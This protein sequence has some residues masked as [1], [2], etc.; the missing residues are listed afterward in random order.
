MNRQ[1]AFAHLIHEMKW[2]DEKIDTWRKFNAHRLRRKL[3]E[4]L[5]RLHRTYRKPYPE[6]LAD[7]QRYIDLEMFDALI[8]AVFGENQ[9]FKCSADERE[10][11][12]FMV[13]FMTH[14]T[15]VETV[16]QE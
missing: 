9:R 6:R 8:V 14:F 4:V 1:E 11:L 10:T 3:H 13:Q 16:N 2:Q 15:T 5:I 12:L 7:V